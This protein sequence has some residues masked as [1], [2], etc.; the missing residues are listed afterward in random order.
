MKAARAAGAFAALLLA[1][2]SMGAIQGIVT[3]PG[4]SSGQLQYQ[5]DGLFSGVPGSAVAGTSVTVGE[6]RGSTAAFGA[7]ASKSTFS[8][9]GAL[10]MAPGA[11]ITL[12]GAGGTVTS[13]SSMTGTH[14]GDGSHLTGIPSTAAVSAAAAAVAADLAAH[15]V[16]TSTHGA[17]AANTADRI[18]LRDGSGNFAAATITAALSGNATTATGLAANGANASSGFL[19]LGVDAA[20]VCEPAHVETSGVSS[21][22]KPVTSGALYTHLNDAA[23]HSAGISGNAATATALAANGTNAGTG[24]IVLGVD[25]SGNAELGA[26]EDTNGGVNGSTSPATANA[27]FDS[28]A[29]KQDLDADLTDLADGELTGSKVGSG[30]PAANIANGTM[31]TVNTGGTAAALTA[32]GSNA[33]SGFLCLGVDASGNCEAGVVLDTAGGVNGSTSPASANVVFDGLATKQAT[34]TDLD[35]LA[36]GSLTGSKIGDGVPAANIA[37]GTMDTDVITSSVGARKVGDAQ[38]TTSGVTA[39]T[40]TLATVTVDAQGRVTSAANGSASAGDAVLVATQNWSGGNT[41]YSTT[42]ARGLLTLGSP[43]GVFVSSGCTTARMMQN[44]S[45]AATSTGSIVV[46]MSKSANNQAYEV[47][48]DTTTDAT[49]GAHGVLVGNGDCAPLAVCPI[50]TDGYLAVKCNSG[51]TVGNR[52]ITSTTRGCGSHLGSVGLAAFGQLIETQS[53][54]ACAPCNVQIGGFLP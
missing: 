17:T 52:I 44:W 35:D 2:P 31:G 5:A 4:G 27:L 37:A 3:E 38:L 7:A 49:V 15:T 22:T 24:R 46:L 42:N 34:D 1:V 8:Y 18:V 47:F 21:S 29:G 43:N 53:S 14:F 12:T 32:N 28:L 54:G 30:V 11:G 40:Y 23:A 25:A 19:C 9:T 36:D 16:A 50:C 33:A 39:N 20:G 51:L 13:A 6:I 26:T 45:G 41:F 10:A 48:T